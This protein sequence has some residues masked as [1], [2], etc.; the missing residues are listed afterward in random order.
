MKQ[1]AQNYKTGEISLL[2][3]PVPA[4]ISG[5]VLVRTEYSLISMGTESMKVRESKMSLVGKGRARPEHVEKVLQSVAQQGALATYKK[6]MNRLDS[7]TPLG[8][9]LCGVVTE[10][11]PGVDDFVVGQRV[12]CGGDQFAHHAQYNWVPKNLCVPVPDGV[13]GEHA[14]FTTVGAIAMQAFRQ[15]QAGLGETACVIGLG[16][17]GQLL[18]QIARSAGLSVFGIDPSDE[19]CELAMQMGAISCSSTDT[20]SFEAMMA[21]LMDVTGGH[22]ADYVFLAVGGNTNQPVEQAVKVAR[23]RARVVDVGKCRLDLPWAPYFEKELDLRFSRSYGPGRYDPTYEVQ[24]IDYPIGYV[25]WTERRN[26]Q[27]FLELLEKKLIDLDPLVSHVLPFDDAISV[28]EKIGKGNYPGLGIV[29]DYPKGN[30]VD[31]AVL[32]RRMPAIAKA[33]AARNG[34]AGTSTDR[35]RLGVVGCGNYAT[36]MILPHLKDRADVSLVEVATATALSSANAQKRFGFERVSTDYQGLLK[37]DGIDAVMIMTRHNSHAAMVC[38]ALRAG[39]TVF[40]EKPLAVNEDQLRAI[41]DT[42]EETGNQR[43]MVGFNRRFSKLLVDLKAA[44]GPLA[45]PQV[46]RYTANAGQL[47]KGSWYGQTGSEGARFVGEGCHFVDVASWWFG[48][49]PAEV[50]AARTTD[51]P[52]NMAATVLYPDGSMAEIAYMTK[53]DP[54]YPKETIEIFGDGKVAK[55]NNF[56]STELWSNGKRAKR[57]SVIGVDKGQSNEVE[58]FISAVRSGG[59]MPISLQSM[60]ST[61]ACTFAALRSATSRRAEPVGM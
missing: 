46:I 18:V 4:T 26:M 10:V 25:R 6:V 37:D 17:L 28:Y 15:A 55:L 5:G 19:R 13:R 23:D 36:T 12:A 38:D 61:T 50:F 24:G 43:L 31:G 14:S 21:K 41:L 57:R 47:E 51:D 2:D 53:G 34:A 22:G 45:G 11:G 32:E 59:D 1:I 35:V 54:R 44:W 39:K 33:T 60:V 48:C 3:V 29:F 52:D 27:C 56:R 7:F 9:S 16:L 49:E 42:I 30:G 40:V 8:Y 58:A 20:E